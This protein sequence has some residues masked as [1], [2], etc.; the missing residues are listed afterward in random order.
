ME[1]AEARGDV[2]DNVAACF[3]MGPGCVH[4]RVL[5]VVTT[6]TIVSGEIGGSRHDFAEP[7]LMLKCQEG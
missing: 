7:E 6:T 2:V 3:D 4:V 5:I 1:A